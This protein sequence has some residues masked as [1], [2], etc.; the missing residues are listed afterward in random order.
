MIKKLLLL[1]SLTFVVA[2]NAQT[3]K[4]EVFETIEK[5]GGVYYAYPNV[6]KQNSTTPKGYEA[7][8]VSHFG[9]HGSRYLISDNDYEWVIKLMRD[10]ESKNALSELGKDVLARLEKVIVEAQGHGGDLSPLGVRQQKGI[11][12]RLYDNYPTIFKD[13]VNMSARST[14]VVRCVLSMDA[15][16]EGL[17]ERNPKLDITQESS[18]KYMYYLN[19]HSEKSNKYT[20]QEGPWREEYR[21]FEASHTKGERL[22]KSLF[23]DSTYILKNVN[24][25]ELIWGFYWIAIDMQNMES[26]IS[27][28]DIFEKQELFDIW[29]AFNYRF[30]VC[31]GNYA[32]NKGLL[33]ANACPALKNIISSADE[34]IATGG[35]GGTFRFAHDG[36]LIP[37]TG[38]M[39]LKDCYN[40]VENP[41]DFYKHFSDFKIAPMAGNIQIVF[42][43]N[44][45]NAND[46]VVK[47][48]HNEKE[49]SIPVKTDI[50]P[51]YKWSDVKEYYNE[52]IN[53]YTIL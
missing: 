8:Y 33:L 52:I 22:T 28:F 27:F 45:K 7:F 16:C 20:S 3:S 23:S 14:I 17:K 41:Y 1:L 25:S 19:Y 24:P 37:L 53:T 47:F 34:V 21:K 49:T 4:E 36:N 44:K 15:F 11:A 51:Y 32:G 42:F 29:Q 2:V 46:I 10:A 50:Y 43:R 40:S 48:L 39:R 6:E 9:R 18:N 5:A 38:L 31:D 30:Y 13:N 35:N 12:H 26:D